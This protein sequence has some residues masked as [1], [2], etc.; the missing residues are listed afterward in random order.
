MVIRRR[1]R[2][3]LVFHA[4]KSSIKSALALIDFDLA[5]HFDEPFVLGRIVGLRGGCTRHD[6]IIHP[7]GSIVE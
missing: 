7:P 4:L 1:R 6:G 3:G 2:L 5:G